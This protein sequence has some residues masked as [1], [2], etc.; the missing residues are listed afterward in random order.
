MGEIRSLILGLPKRC[1][2]NPHGLKQMMWFGKSVIFVNQIVGLY[3][4]EIGL[5]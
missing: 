4:F 3:V 5:L 2:L 1:T